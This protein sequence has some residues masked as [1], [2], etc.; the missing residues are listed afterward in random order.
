M[1]S[2]NHLTPH[3]RGIVNRYYE[4]K[5]TIMLGKLSEIVSELYLAESEKKKASLWKSARLAL[6]NLDSDS[7][8]TDKIFDARDIKALAE[9]VNALSKGAAK[10]DQS[11]SKPRPA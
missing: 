11:A 4:H 6:A 2:G 1:A 10:P 9:L 5:D 3:Q 8:Q 7:P